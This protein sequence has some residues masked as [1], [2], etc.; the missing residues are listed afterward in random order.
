MAALIVVQKVHVVLIFSRAT[1]ERGHDVFLY[2]RICALLREVLLL[3]AFGGLTPRLLLEAE[4]G[5]KV[6]P[7]SAAPLSP[8]SAHSCLAPAMPAPPNAA[9]TP[10]TGSSAE[11]YSFVSFLQ[12]VS[13]L[14]VN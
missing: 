3:P 5:A 7:L 14:A 9:L 11:N 4:K 6:S 2:Y 12:E 10:L 8:A 1:H 13:L